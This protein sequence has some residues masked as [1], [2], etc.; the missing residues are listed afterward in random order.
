[1]G[2]QSSAGDGGIKP[3]PTDC[4]DKVSVNGS[5]LIQFQLTKTQE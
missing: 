4:V 3:G 5:I 2:G 1:M